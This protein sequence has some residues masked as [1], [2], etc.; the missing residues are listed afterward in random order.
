[1]KYKLY[2]TVQTISFSILSVGCIEHA[3][4][5]SDKTCLLEAS[6]ILFVT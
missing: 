4:P 3:K 2:H 6:H 5:F 1:M